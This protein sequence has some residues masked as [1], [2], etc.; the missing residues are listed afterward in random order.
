MKKISL[1]AIILTIPLWAGLAFSGSVK[2][3]RISEDDFSFLHESDI[4]G[5]DIL[6]GI[7][8]VGIDVAIDEKELIDLEA[9]GV[10]PTVLCPDLE[11][12][13]MA[14]SWAYHS[15]NDAIGFIED[16]ADTYPQITSLEII[17]QSVNGREIQALKISDNPIEDE[18][19]EVDVLFISLHH[20]REWPA[21]EMGLY[22]ADILTSQYD[23]NP[24]IRNIVD[25]EEIYVIPCMNPD[26]YVY[27]HDQGHDWRKNRRYFPEF[28]SY[29]VD[30]N[31]NWGGSCDGNPDGQWGSV[32]GSVSHGADTEVYCG[33]GPFS[34]NENIAVRN[35]M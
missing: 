9:K 23:S 35:F 14:N 21:L 6:A 8:G 33:P 16:I 30:L 22:I 2:V 17:G 32:I 24:E 27:S 29:G 10:F 1:L 20:A 7:P 5:L 28:G 26:G 25:N 11:A 31:R 18:Q 3:I 13:Q 4:K 19:D 12:V 34:E 15:W